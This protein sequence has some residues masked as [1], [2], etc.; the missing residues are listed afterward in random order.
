M[1]WYED[2]KPDKWEGPH[3]GYG[4]DKHTG[5]TLL[6]QDAGNANGATWKEVLDMWADNSV[7]HQSASTTFKDFIC[8]T[9]GEHLSA[10]VFL[11]VYYNVA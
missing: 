10:D 11:S 4:I 3:T 9:E 7:L 8:K 2:H 1:T 6:L 5:K